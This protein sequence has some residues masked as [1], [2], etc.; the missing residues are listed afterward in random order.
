MN[1]KNKTRTVSFD[2]RHSL[3]VGGPLAR[4]ASTFTSNM[5][6]SS[7]MNGPIGNTTV[8][9]MTKPKM[10]SESEIE[11]WKQQPMAA[12]RKKMLN[13]DA[14]AMDY[15]LEAWE[16]DCLQN[17]AVHVSIRVCRP[18]TKGG[19]ARE[20]QGGRGEGGPARVC[21]WILLRGWT[22]DAL[23]LAKSGCK[24]AVNSR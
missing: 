22:K 19:C 16:D 15:T 2:A 20:L 7:A 24:V 13:I 21:G 18:F 8:K 5:K 3:H 12:A 14:D 4:N 11:R 9:R 1:R 17:H 23:N 10:P 6:P